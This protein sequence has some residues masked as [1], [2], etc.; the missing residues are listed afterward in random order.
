MQVICVRLEYLINRNASVKNQYLK[1][2]NCLQTNEYSSY[3]IMF[4]FRQIHLGK[5]WTPLS[6][7]GGAHGVMVI[8]IGNG[9]DDTSSN[10]GQDWLHFT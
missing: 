7:L 2:F 8:V 1:T 10:P 6:L 3:A 4:T 9:H 5:V